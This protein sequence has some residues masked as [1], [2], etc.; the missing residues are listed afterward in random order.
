MKIP[1]PYAVA[2]ELVLFRESARMTLPHLLTG[3]VGALAGAIGFVG[4]VRG[5]GVVLAFVFAVMVCAVAGY[6]AFRMFRLVLPALRV[7][8]R[9]GVVAIPNRQRMRAKVRSYCGGMAGGG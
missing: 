8:V 6:G 2:A 9:L 7:L 3:C 5:W 1:F 4:T